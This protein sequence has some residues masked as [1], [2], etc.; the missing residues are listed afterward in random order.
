MRDAPGS[1]A[2]LAT[3]PAAPVEGCY[4]PQADAAED[5]SGGAASSTAPTSA[6]HRVYPLVQ[7]AQHKARD[8]AAELD[9]LDV[10]EEKANNQITANVEAA[11]TALEVAEHSLRRQL[12]E[13][14]AARRAALRSELRTADAA[15]DRAINATDAVA[16][17]S[18][19]GEK[20]RRCG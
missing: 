5:G 18:Q 10:Y 14:T 4:Q 11:R 7:C 1:R 12:C 15:L 6:P 2:M 19:D 8:V 3:A 9:A 20:G 17:A 13:E 16:Q